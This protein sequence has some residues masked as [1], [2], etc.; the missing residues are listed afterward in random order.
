MRGPSGGGT[1]CNGAAQ[2]EQSSDCSWS[3]RSHWPR[4]AHSGL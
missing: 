3:A 2:L 1:R 4:A